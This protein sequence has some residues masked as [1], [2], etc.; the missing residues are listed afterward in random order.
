M[1]RTASAA[2][3]LAGLAALP[4]PADA[5]GADRCDAAGV[6]IDSDRLTH[7]P[8]TGIWSA[9]G[10]VQ[11]RHQ[12]RTLLTEQVQYRRADGA[13]EIPDA[14]RLVLP[15]G[16]RIA[17]R[18]GQYTAALDQGAMRDVRAFPQG[19]AGRIDADRAVLEDA[20]L[21]LERAQFSPCPVAPDNPTPAWQVR[22]SRATYDREAQ[23]LIFDN[24]RFEAF[25]VPV[26][27]LPRLRMP[28]PEV[29]RRTGFL[30]PTFHSSNAYGI[31]VKTPYHF[32]L[33]PDR[34]AWLTPFATSRDG[35]LL[36]GTYRQLFAQ[37]ETTLAGSV[38]HP[39]LPASSGQERARGH[40]FANATFW[41][42]ADTVLG[43][44]LAVASHRGYLR[45]YGY[46]DADRLRNRAYLERHAPDEVIEAEILGFQSQRDGERSDTLPVL[47]PQLRY[48][49]NGA[50]GG[51]LGGGWTIGADLRVLGR[52]EGRDVS[53][54]GVDAEW[55][56]ELVFADRFRLSFH[57]RARL[58]HYRSSAPFGVVGDMR[59][60]AS[61]AF[62]SLGAEVGYPLVR[63]GAVGVEYLEPFAQV[64]LAPNTR[65][66][67]RVPNEDSINVEFDTVSLLSRDRFTG[68][69]RFEPGNRA[70]IGLRY[71][72]QFAGSTRFE[73]AGGQA[74]RLREADAF[75]AGSGLRRRASDYVGAWSLSRGA[76]APLQLLHRFRLSP[77]FDVQRSDFSVTTSVRA[78]KLGVNY[79]FL[80]R[81]PGGGAQ[82]PGRPERGELQAALDVPL[83]GAWH[84]RLDGRRDTELHRSISLG[85]RI[86]YVHPCFVAHFDITR[87]Y[88]ESTDVPAGVEVGVYFELL[89]FG[90]D[91]PAA[92]R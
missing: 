29:E 37:G 18:A 90:G 27:W 13:V 24:A 53:S 68:N 41:T 74:L 60:S 83:F 25:G 80:E 34:A 11:V 50:F 22:A 30:L 14:F 32:A 70:A 78:A 62:G 3:F 38:T 52:Q 65:N 56:R 4:H 47:L 2:L 57:G 7:D 44:D 17:G 85:G 77:A 72:R 79:V 63:T 1:I 21:V 69:D 15:D 87:N 81:D 33:A 73:I 84:L 58:D 86:S 45:R 66:R 71:A 55:E 16:S 82:D 67:H 36:E 23:D 28:A 54:L 88:N 8:A 48:R 10:D 12:G 64:V 51:R 59:R 61:R 5:T 49:R 35:I 42:S 91:F 89:T 31:G 39:S 40:L 92:N 26:G 9:S 20:R 76:T 6:A 46:S 43:T 19:G 75:S